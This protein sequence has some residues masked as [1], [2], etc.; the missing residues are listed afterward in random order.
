PESPKVVVIN[1]KMARKWW[2]HESAVGKKIKQGFP[3]DKSP[4]REI[5]GVVG[6]VPQNGLDEPI[7]TEV[8]LPMTQMQTDGM[9]LLVRTTGDPMSLAKAVSAKIHALD[10]DQAVTAVQP[11]TQYVA[12]SLARRRFHT[13]LLGAF[14][15]LALLLA[16]VGIYGVVSYGV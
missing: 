7:R 5:V 16:S 12:E 15:A 1:E 9:T 8:F 4:Y 14:G 6:D 2:P 10:K 13:L 3:Q 11:M